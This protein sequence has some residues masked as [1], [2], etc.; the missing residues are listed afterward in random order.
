MTP[1]NIGAIAIF[2]AWG[3]CLFALGASLW[4]ARRQQQR[5][6]LAAQT[7]QQLTFFLVTLACLLMFGLL[8]NNTYAVAYV[9]RVTNNATPWY[10]RLT[11]LWGG[12]AGSLLFWSWLV[13]TYTSFALQR[14]WRNAKDLQ[15]YV[16]A[17]FALTLG[18]FL[19]L[20]NFF[21][22]PFQKIWVDAL[23]YPT[24]GMFPK[25][26]EILATPADGQGL[27]PLL[28]HIG[29]IIHPPML[30]LGFV[31]FIVPFA[32]AIASLIAGRSDAYWIQA[33]RRYTLLAWLFLSLGLLLGGRW[34]YDVL[35]WGGYWGW[36]PVEV[37]AFMP[38]L[39]ATAFLHSV[40]IQEKQGMFKH[41]NLL[42]MILTFCLVVLG[43]FLTRSGVFSSVHAFAA[44]NLGPVFF[45]FIAFSFIGSAGLLIWRWRSLQ[46]ESRLQSWFSKEGLFLLNNLLFLAILFTCLWGVLYPLF[47]ELLTGQAATVGAPFYER[48]TA[49]M[50]L[51][52]L[53]LMGIAPLA[54]YRASSARLLGK[55]IW[56]PLL[57]TVP[58][59]IF[60]LWWGVREPLTLL[61]LVLSTLVASVTLLEFYKGASA[62]QR[63]KSESFGVAL[64][65]LVQ[66]NHRRYGGYCVH[67]GVVL[68][69]LGI[70]GI[71]S[72][73]RQTQGTIAAGESLQIGAY[74]VQYQT[75]HSFAAADGRA[76]TRAT[77]QVYQG[78]HLLGTIYP[79][80]DNY[81]Q[82]RQVMSIPGV[83]SSVQG[84]VYVLLVGWK[85]IGT[86]GATFK[87]YINPLI[88]WLW[89]GGLLFIIGTLI[90][91]MQATN[92]TSSQPIRGST[93]SLVNS[94]E[95]A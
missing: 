10:L 24:E 74:R 36:D 49:P 80:Q 43:T 70:I 25:V 20:N 94:H 53:L 65:H 56:L 89:L 69:A 91:G 90:S 87:I 50:F 81:Q 72:F 60:C 52:I 68:M 16:I 23:G 55:A 27:N 88:N 14:N 42:L 54:A 9:T 77:V 59:L 37:A 15:P 85:P 79:R 6:V 61:G 28:R 1:A 17:V 26:G 32:Y 5:W 82:Q 39:S 86:E 8:L 21:E 40:L 95:P 35:G 84:D 2:L 57:C 92:V 45:G 30:Y 93:P 46:S 71:E 63:S 78:D 62:R 34:A 19:T 66:R 33:S 4:G 12:Q 75:L 48:T 83:H 67:L 41:W 47:S 76:V 64:W 18:F 22:N 31:G 13:A 38:W 3:C 11:A 58:V 7:A 73:Q 44:S 29:M 51:G